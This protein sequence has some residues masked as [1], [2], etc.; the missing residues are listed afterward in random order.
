[1]QFRWCLVFYHAMTEM[2][3]HYSEKWFASMEECRLNA[4]STDV[5]DYCCG[6][7]FLFESRDI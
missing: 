1:V 3:R 7:E 4:E 5:G 6:F 2:S